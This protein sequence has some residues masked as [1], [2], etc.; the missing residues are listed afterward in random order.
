[1]EESADAPVFS[2]GNGDVVGVYIDFNFEV[3]SSSSSKSNKQ[4][5]KKNKRADL[6]LD[7]AS[8]SI[9]FSLN[10]H[11][12][13]CAFEAK[14]TLVGGK[15]CTPFVPVI[16][17]ESGESVKVNI[18]QCPFKYYAAPPSSSFTEF[19]PVLQN[20]S[21]KYSESIRSYV[22]FYDTHVRSNAIGDGHSISTYAVDSVRSESALASTLDDELNKSAKGV[23]VHGEHAPASSLPIEV[24]HSVD[25]SVAPACTFTFDSIDVDSSE[26][27]SPELF[28]HFGMAHLKAELERRGLKSGG[29]ILERSQRLFLIRGVSP[30]KIDKKLK[31]KSSSGL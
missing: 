12:L 1:M 26:F 4:S 19:V 27:T 16:S 22:A 15:A 11:Y 7:L 18:G 14:D 2:W 3:A 17:V 25:S 31:A 8:P 21:D 23:D 9:A 29:T 30:Y 6:K 13:G 24:N 20:L 5:G 28:F 10:G